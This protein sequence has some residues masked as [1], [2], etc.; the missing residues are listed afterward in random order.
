MQSMEKLMMH[1]AEPR[2]PSVA[3]VVGGRFFAFDIARALQA[4]GRLAAIVS[5]YPKAL[6]ERIALSHLRWNPLLAV[7]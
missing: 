1:G 4:R 2:D 5:A 6:R 7:R 3:I